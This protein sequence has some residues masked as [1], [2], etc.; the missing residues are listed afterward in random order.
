MSAAEGTDGL[1]W[2]DAVAEL[3][4]IVAEL[5]RDDVDVDVL[6]ERVQRA[7]VLTTWCRERLASVRHQVEEVTLRL[8]PEGMAG[9]NDEESDES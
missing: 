4:D 1:T 9:S 6:A 3:D 8:A 7:E 2:A 5:D